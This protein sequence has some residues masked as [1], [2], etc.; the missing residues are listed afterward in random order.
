[1]KKSLSRVLSLA[2]VLVMVLGVMPMAAAADQNFDPLSISDTTA[3]LQP[4]ETKTLT[5]TV[6]ANNN[7]LSTLATIQWSTTDSAVATVSGNQNTATVTA[8]AAGTATIT[9]NISYSGTNTYSGTVSCT[10]TVEEAEP[11]VEYDVE[12]S[13]AKVTLLPGAEYTIVNP[14]VTAS[15][16]SEVPELTWTWASSTGAVTVSGNKITAGTAAG[17]AKITGTPSIEAVGTVSFDVEVVAGVTVTADAIELNV[18]ASKTIALKADPQVDGLTAT[19]KSANTKIATVDSTGKVT[20]VTEGTTTIAVTVTPPTGVKLNGAGTDG[21][22]TFNVD[23]NVKDGAYIKSS[24]FSLLQGA[25]QSL[26]ITPVGVPEGAVVTYGYQVKDSTAATVS[27]ATNTTGKVTVTAAKKDAVSEIT[28]TASYKVGNADSVALDPITVKF[29]VYS[30]H[31]IKAV[32]LETVTKSFNFEDTKIFKSVSYDGYTASTYKDLSLVAL[33]SENT[34]SQSATCFM[35]LSEGYGSDDIGTLKVGN[36]SSGRFASLGA[37]RAVFTLNGKTGTVI[38]NYT[39]DKGTVEDNL[40]LAKGSIVIETA[41]SK[42]DI[43]YETTYGNAVT[44]DEDDFEDFWKKYGTGTLDH[45]T[46]DVS[47]LVPAYGS[48]YIAKNSNQKVT[49]VMEFEPNYKSNNDTYDLD[50]VTYVPSSVKSEYVEEIPFTCVSTTN[51]SMS[52]V[53][54]IEVSGKLPFTDVKESHWFY[55]SVAYVYNSGIMN[56]T[57]DTLFSPNET[58]TRAM[59]VTMLYRIENQPSVTFKGTFSDV[60]SGQWYSNAV[61]WAAKNDIV[62]GMGD[63]TFGYAK[64][65][66]REQF[67]AILYRYA[68]YKNISTSG[69]SSLTKFSDYK[70]VSSYAESALKW[71]VYEGIINGDGGK[72]LPKGTATRAQA[73]KMI[74]YFLEGSDIDVSGDDNKTTATGLSFYANDAVEYLEEDIGLKRNG[75]VSLTVVGDEYV[76]DTTKHDCIGIVVYYKYK[77]VLGSIYSDQMVFVYDLDDNTVAYDATEYY[78]WLA[79]S[80][81]DDLTQWEKFV[82]YSALTLEANAL[83]AKANT[84]T[85]ITNY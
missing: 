11:E 70:T 69:Q 31:T 41:G 73:A 51:V 21:K 57:T 7:D 5:V 68:D 40:I 46:F 19:F 76:S 83:L 66:T 61:E 45:V 58:L 23:V 29:S 85:V 33:M 55:D 80:Y 62:N 72:L 64:A 63:G 32:L 43:I 81:A 77:T 42:A 1:M 71:A 79:D 13:S 15:D 67:A 50:T 2:L 4:E 60:K 37:E 20:G 65:I 10:V 48:L 25:S 30:E 49:W 28:V 22:Y 16:D 82:Y 12:F 26:Q 56:G 3:T 84:M 8:V 35:T 53:M 36:S 39:L 47:T 14:V 18:E 52:G 9:A 78:D 75:F 38:I 74:H 17:T 59:V 54:A 34:W 44:I 24:N 6:G 27:E